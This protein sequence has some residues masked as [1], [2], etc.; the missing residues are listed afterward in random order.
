MKYDLVRKCIFRPYGDNFP[1]FYLTVW[2]ADCTREGKTVLGY[3]LAMRDGK[4]AALIFQNEDFAVSPLHAIDS[5]ATIAALMNFLT[6]RP[7]DTDAEYF[8]S[9]TAEQ[10]EFAE[11]YAEALSVHVADR[12]GG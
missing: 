9:Y 5:D 10:L 6:L 2:D 8:S 3:R 12:F 1:I 11:T 4:G 7:G